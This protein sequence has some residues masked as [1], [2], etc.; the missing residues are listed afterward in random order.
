MHQT[1]IYKYR[2]S[3]ATAVAQVDVH[4][5]FRLQTGF[6]M[7]LTFGQAA[8]SSSVGGGIIAHELGH[9][10]GM[11]DAGIAPIPPSVMNNPANPPPGGCTAPLVGT[12]NVQPGDATTAQRCVGLGRS[13]FKITVSV[14]T[15]HRA[16]C[17]TLPTTLRDRS[18][19]RINIQPW[20]G[21]LMVLLI[22]TRWS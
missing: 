19:V 16:K 15:E 21:M 5:V 9:S 3:R 18:R 8:L 17:K 14:K 20:L 13:R 12:S 6:T 4:P 7:D 22:A 2:G 1:P 11:I 10:L